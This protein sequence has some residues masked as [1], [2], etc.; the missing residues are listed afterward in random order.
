M[1]ISTRKH[2]CH[3]QRLPATATRCAFVAI[4]FAGCLSACSKSGGDTPAA[5][6]APVSVAV[7]PSVAASAPTGPVDN[8]C[9]LLTDAE[10]RA[11]YP[12]AT[13]G[14]RNTESLQY[15]LDRCAWNTPA[16]QIG[17]EVSKVEAAAFPKELR[18]E[19]QG[20]VDPRVQGAL[21]GIKFH[22]VDGIGDHA[23][24]VLE[25]GDAK[26]GIYT[27]I[28]LLAIQRGHRMAVLMVHERASDA[29]LPSL[30]TLQNLGRRL[31]LR[32]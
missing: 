20:A 8:A 16:G 18:A 3:R 1:T 27:D 12:N 4:L 24:A 31:A 23:I 30:D 29:P 9:N 15:G 22:A 26:R 19:L 5:A 25:K 21:D 17:V 6:S 13:A 7:Q 28:A 14:K 11:V 32:L 10:V 2:E